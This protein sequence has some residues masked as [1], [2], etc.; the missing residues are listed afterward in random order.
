MSNQRSILTA[1]RPTGTDKSPVDWGWWVVGVVA[2]YVVLFFLWTQFH[3]G[4]KEYQLLIGNLATLPP[5]IALVTLCWRTSLHPALTPRVRWGWR[6]LTVAASCYLIVNSVFWPYYELI[7]EQQPYLSW[8]HTGIVGCYLF[9]LLG[10]ILLMEGLES[11]AERLKFCLDA[12]IMLVGVSTPIWYL[13]MR[14]IAVADQSSLPA[15]TL[16]LIH[17]STALLMLFGALA[18]LFK[19]AKLRNASPLQWLVVGM[20]VYYTADL[21]FVSQ[22]LK[23]TYQTGDSLDGVYTIANLLMMIGAQLAYARA[24]A[25]GATV[26]THRQDDAFKALP[27][28]AIVLVYGLLLAVAGDDWEEPLGGLLVAAVILTALLLVRQIVANQENLRLRAEQDQHESEA[29]FAALVR[30][31]SDLITITD[32]YSVIQFISPVVRDLL[33]YEPELL[34][35]TPLLALLHPEDQ[36]QGRAFFRDTLREVGVTATIEWRMRCRDESWLYVE[37]IASNLQDDH[38]VQGIVLNSRDISERRALEEQLRQLAFHDSLTR[39]ANRVLFRD[40]VEHALERAQRSRQPIAVMFLDLDNFKAINDS[41]GHSEGDRLLVTTAHQLVCHTRACD[42]VA[43]LGG[44]EFAVLIEDVPPLEDLQHLAQRIVEALYIAFKLENGDVLVTAS[45]G[46]V[47]SAGEESVDELLRNA[48][49]A[50]YAAKARGKHRYEIFSSKMNS[51]VRD[52]LQLET[53]LRRAL[54]QGGELQ[55]HYQPIMNLKTGQLFGVEALARWQHPTLNNIPPATFIPIAEETGLIVPLGRWILREA[56]QQA[57]RWRDKFPVGQEPYIAVN[58]STYQLQHTDFLTHVADELE[59]AGISPDVMVLEFTES[60]MMRNTAV[61]LD[62][63]R[64][65]NALGVRLAIDDFGAG[66]SALSYLGRFP[67]HLLKIDRSLIEHLGQGGEGAVLTRA[68]IALGETL[69]IQMVA[70]GIEGEGQLQELRRL[71]CHLGQ[72]YLFSKPVA[73]QEITWLAA[74]GNW[75]NAAGFKTP[76]AAHSDKRRSSAATPVPATRQY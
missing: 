66:Y 36:A 34:H 71:G 27:Y 41:L 5:E 24:E 62:R 10:I 74:G 58:V 11:R 17:P 76:I 70:E 69:K 57:R 46:V 20:L 7:L 12:G 4:G 64:E 13:H 1:F 50:M 6:S 75:G 32:S 61:A 67:I 16:F 53:D 68:I 28:L 19:G 59:Q 37:T 39:L 8:N 49:T 30:K 44:D 60:V 40:R 21:V 72:G 73:V 3:W 23:G 52:R 31:S 14:P 26:P 38:V 9:A 45:M 22:A 51:V 54:E 35:Q 48:D 63:L 25:G 47:I 33:G 18:V 65:L 15:T 56:C 55:L 43:R 42:T 29:R 2:V